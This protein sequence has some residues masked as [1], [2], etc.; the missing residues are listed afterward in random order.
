MDGGDDYDEISSTLFQ[1][2]RYFLEY[3]NPI[4]PLPY[5][6]IIYKLDGK[7][8]SQDFEILGHSFEI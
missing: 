4:W 3:L 5:E 7:I 2:I 8:Y 1:N 6:V